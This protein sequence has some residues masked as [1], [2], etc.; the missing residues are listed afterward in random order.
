MVEGGFGYLAIEK[1]FSEADGA[2]CKYNA[3]KLPF[4]RHVNL[5]L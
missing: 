5:G 4:L 2:K 3:L 1:K